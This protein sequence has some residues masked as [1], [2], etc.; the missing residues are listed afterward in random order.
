MIRHEC[1][2]GKV[3]LWMK[4]LAIFLYR[5]VILVFYHNVA[6]CC[7]CRWCSI[8]YV[9]AVKQML[10]LVVEGV[11]WLD[12]TI[13][14]PAAWAHTNNLLSDYVS[15]SLLVSMQSI[16]FPLLLAPE[17]SIHLIGVSRN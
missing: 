17:I 6:Y 11:S 13:S 12:V 1:M 8:D 2:K 10:V 5:S 15:K 4:S 14:Q 9:T 16:Y 7:V 3:I